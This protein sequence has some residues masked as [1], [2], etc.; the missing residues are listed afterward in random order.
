MLEVV[1]E[2]LSCHEV[3]VLEAQRYRNPV[4]DNAT[5]VASRCERFRRLYRELDPAEAVAVPA[6]YG[7]RHRYIAPVIR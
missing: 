4:A 3:F 5:K 7:R 1:G 6:Q 2:H